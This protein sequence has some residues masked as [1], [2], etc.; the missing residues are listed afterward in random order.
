MKISSF[1]KHYS[2]LFPIGRKEY[3][4]SLDDKDLD[5]LKIWC[6]QLVHQYPIYEEILETITDI[7]FKRL[8][9]DEKIN[10]LIF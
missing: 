1:V 8:N 10:S 6:D 3:I 7:Q 9:R 2:R 4:Q 5:K